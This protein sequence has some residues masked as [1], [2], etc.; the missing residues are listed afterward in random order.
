MFFFFLTRTGKKTS[1]VSEFISHE[2]QEHR[3]GN[4]LINLKLSKLVN[5]YICTNIRVQCSSYYINLINQLKF[6]VNIQFT[7]EFSILGILLMS[8]GSYVFSTTQVPTIHFLFQLNYLFT[9]IKSAFQ[10]FQCQWR[11]QNSLNVLEDKNVPRNK[12]NLESIEHNMCMFECIF[13]N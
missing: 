8:I 5:R 4:K 1:E 6:F 13:Q 12:R 2:F 3:H 9:L 10:N 7:Q 11:C